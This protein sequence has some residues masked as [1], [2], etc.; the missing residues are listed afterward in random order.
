LLLEKL[1]HTNVAIDC[2]LS[3]I[4][5]NGQYTLTFQFKFLGGNSIDCD[6]LNQNLDN[7]LPV[8]LDHVLNGE[9][10]LFFSALI[11]PAVEL[12]EGRVHAEANEAEVTL[13]LKMNLS[14]ADNYQ[15]RSVNREST[16]KSCNYNASGNPKPYLYYWKAE[17]LEEPEEVQI[18]E[19]PKPKAVTEVVPKPSGPSVAA[20]KLE[21]PQQT[22]LNSLDR[23]QP[24]QLNKSMPSDPNL[25]R[26]DQKKAREELAKLSMGGIKNFGSQEILPVLEKA[27]SQNNI[28]A[29]FF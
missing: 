11:K 5:N 10:I 28:E 22:L 13:Y 18:V 21:S 20:P 6:T 4:T 15:E 14:V 23:P 25:I 2:D 8:S 26:I 3:S 12:F 24:P 1:S 9:D 16:M 7:D 27:G 17:E 19:Q 29:L